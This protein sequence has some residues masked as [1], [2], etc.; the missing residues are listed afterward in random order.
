MII[1][2]C[3]KCIFAVSDE[4]AQ[5]GCSLNIPTSIISEFPSC[6]TEST[7]KTVDNYYEL[8]DFYCSY[9]RTLEWK[10]NISAKET[11]VDTAIHEETRIKYNLIML[12]EQEDL[13]NLFTNLNLIYSGNYR[14]SYITLITRNIDHTSLNS[15]K[16]FIQNIEKVCQWKMFNILDNEMTHSETIDF[17]LENNLLLDKYNLLIIMNNHYLI[18]NHFLEAT[19]NIVNSF[20]EKR[21]VIIPNNLLSFTNTVIPTNLY[22]TME[23]KIGLVLDHLDHTNDIYKFCIE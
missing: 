20:L 11:D 12:V 9:A 2:R 4:N 23:N 8:Q 18:Q 13:A 22:Q 19:N 10:A 14:P 5:T 17:S 3:K 7:L 15:I 1:T 21:A 6:Y 16:L